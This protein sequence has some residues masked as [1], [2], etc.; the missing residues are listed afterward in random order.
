MKPY[1]ILLILL[2]LLGACQT[3]PD[4]PTPVSPAVVDAAPTVSAVPTAIFDPS[5]DLIFI[6][7]EAN[8][9]KLV[10]LHT[11]ANELTTLFTAQAPAILTHVAAD[12][13]NGLLL[14]AYAPPSDDGSQI[15]DTELYILPLEGSS[16]PIP[17]VTRQQSDER[18]LDPAFSA[19]GRFLYFAHVAPLADGA[20]TTSLERLDLQAGTSAL[21]AE[22]GLLPTV[23]PD[24]RFLAYIAINPAT[25]ERVLTLSQLDGSNPQPLVSSRLLSGVSQPVFAP[26]SQSIYFTAGS[27]AADVVQNVPSDWWRVSVNGGDPTRVMALQQVDMGGVFSPDGRFLAFAGQA[28]VFLMHPDGGG[29]L[30]LQDVVAGG[31]L[32]WL[33]QTV[34]SE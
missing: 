13:A 20:F 30:Q 10:R 28:G 11:A 9:Q 32:V 34:S 19:D 33:P 26:D 7:I 22:N 15:G 1:P 16:D 31:S 17:L 27:A 5:G 6:Q 21:I 4:L 14:V 24:G 3:A 29:L 2:L 25:Q 8:Q 18:F 23:S 12:P